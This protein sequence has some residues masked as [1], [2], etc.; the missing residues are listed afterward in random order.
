VRLLEKLPLIHSLEY[1]VAHEEGSLAAMATVFLAYLETHPN[2][3]EIIAIT[4][5]ELAAILQSVKGEDSR[6]FCKAAQRLKKMS[7]KA[8]R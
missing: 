4:A 5:L 6:W 8:V 3:D 7:S 2:P 1:R